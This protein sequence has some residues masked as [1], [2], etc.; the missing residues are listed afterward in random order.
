MWAGASQGMRS[1]LE[2]LDHTVASA[3]CFFKDSGSGEARQADAK[4]ILVPFPIPPCPTEPESGR[5]G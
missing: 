4:P 1:W 3:W 5:W 2:A